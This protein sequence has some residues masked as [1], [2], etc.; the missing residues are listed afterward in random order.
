[1]IVAKRT[2]ILSFIALCTGLAL[3]S[4]ALAHNG[5]HRMT[6][7]QSLLHELAWTETLAAS[8]TIAALGTMAAWRLCQRKAAYRK[9]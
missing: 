3:A 5:P 7:L 8:L 2:N 6:Y 4:P 9:L 1:M